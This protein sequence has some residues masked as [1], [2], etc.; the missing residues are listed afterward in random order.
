MTHELTIIDDGL[1]TRSVAYTLIDQLTRDRLGRVEDVIAGRADEINVDELTLAIKVDSEILHNDR[2]RLL[3]AAGLAIQ[4]YRENP[5]GLSQDAFLKRLAR[6]FQVDLEAFRSY[7]LVLQYEIRHRQ[8][9]GPSPLGNLP[10]LIASAERHELDAPELLELR[11]ATRFKHHPS[12]YVTLAEQGLNNTEIA[13]HFGDV[14]EATVRRGLTAAGY[15]RSPAQIAG[16]EALGRDASIRDGWRRPGRAALGS[17]PHPGREREP[18]G[19]AARDVTGEHQRA[20]RLARGG[21]QVEPASVHRQRSA[22]G[23]RPAGLRA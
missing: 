15:R 4:Y 10:R 12:E 2:T 16:T 13:K 11:P 7:V 8:R 19:V 14:S 5:M 20:R 23:S 22:G 9:T 6:V 17:D 18:S 1:P 21:W 3:R